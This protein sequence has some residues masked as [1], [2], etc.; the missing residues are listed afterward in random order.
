MQLQAEGGPLVERD[1]RLR[2]AVDV[3][4][5]LRLHVAVDRVDDG[6]DDAVS[7]RLR[8]YAFGVLG[9]VQAQ[10]AGDILGRDTRVR[11]G[12]SSDTCTIRRLVMIKN[13]L[14]LIKLIFIWIWF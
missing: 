4:Q 9:R 10:F 1:L 7:D 11:G 8:D 14:I 6:F 12:D 2:R 5:L 13:K 3:D